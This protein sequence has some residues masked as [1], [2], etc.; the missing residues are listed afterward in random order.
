MSGSICQMYSRRPSTGTPPLLASSSTSL[1]WT[2][3]P[4]QTIH[5]LDLFLGQ[6]RSRQDGAYDAR[7]VNE[8]LLLWDHKF[9]GCAPPYPHRRHVCCQEGVGVEGHV[10]RR[11]LEAVGLEQPQRAV[12]DPVVRRAAGRPQLHLQPKTYPLM[13]TIRVRLAA[14]RPETVPDCSK[15]TANQLEFR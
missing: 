9:Q 15:L 11:V 12:A 1:R 7:C 4:H 6:H 2:Q 5:N 10:P 14:Q 3:P 13:R 8:H